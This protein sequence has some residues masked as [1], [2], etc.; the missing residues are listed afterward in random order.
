M[1]SVNT[2]EFSQ[3]PEAVQKAI[4]RHEIEHIK[5]EHQL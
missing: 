5:K 3:L 2:T 1:I 4:I